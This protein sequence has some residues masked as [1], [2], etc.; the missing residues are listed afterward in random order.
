M[1]TVCSINIVP[2]GLFLSH[3]HVLA[4]RDKD[5]FL[6]LSEKQKRQLDRW[7]RPSDYLENPEMIMAISCFSI[8]Q[9]VVTDCSFVAS[10]AIAAQYERRF[11]KRLITNIIYPQRNGGAVYN[12]CGMYMVRLNINGVSRKVSSTQL[13]CFASESG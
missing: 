13:L 8:R 11:K 7:V 12:P 2:R 5:G 9:T 10:M 1:P 6:I 3:P 4:H